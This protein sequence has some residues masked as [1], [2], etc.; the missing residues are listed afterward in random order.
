M[1]KITKTQSVLGIVAVAVGFVLM[2]FAPSAAGYKIGDSVADFSLKNTVDGK[3]VSMASFPKAKGYI[4]MFTCNHCPF[5]KKYEQRIMDLDKKYAALGYP[6]IAISPN[7]PS[8]EPEDSYDE[9]G[10][11][12]KEKKYTFPYA[13]DE[14]QQVAAAF[15]A[16]KTPHAFIVNK[17]NGK[18]VLKYMGAI[19]DNTDSAEKATKHYVADA[20]DALIGGKAVAVTETKSVG[21]G[22][23]WKKS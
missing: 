16:T 18:L 12:A 3:A 11:H 7:D 21:C 15:G 10:K 6:V 1:K 13:F 2:S 20:V 4:V 17:E 19:D 14:T 23:K 8:I 5:A 9:L 22:V